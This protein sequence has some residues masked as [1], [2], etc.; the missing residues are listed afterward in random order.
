[1]T[2]QITPIRTASAT[3]MA[4][5]AAGQQ[6]G[7]GDRA[8]PGHQRDGQREGRDVAHMLL[9]RLLGR[10]RLALDAHAE[11]HFGGDREQQQPAGDAERRQRDAELVPSSQSPIS[12]VPARMAAAIRLARAARPAAARL[13]GSP[14]GDGQKGRRQADGSTTTSSVTSGGDEIIECH[15]GDVSGRPARVNARCR[16]KPSAARPDG[17]CAPNRACAASRAAC[18]VI[19]ITRENIPPRR[20]FWVGVAGAKSAKQICHQI[21]EGISFGRQRKYRRRATRVPR[22]SVPSRSRTR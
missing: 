17:G 4:V 21:R 14:V 15:G 19:E 3:G 5:G 13:A 11:H 1:M 10:L 8:R 6:Q 2:T 16:G 9:D 20:A 18:N 7:R 12:A 22:T